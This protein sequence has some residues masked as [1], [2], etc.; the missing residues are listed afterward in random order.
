MPPMPRE[1]SG[2]RVLVLW[3]QPEQN[4]GVRPATVGSWATAA[5]WASSSAKCCSIRVRTSAG[6]SSLNKR[7]AS[8]RAIKVG[9]KSAVARSRVLALGLGIDHSPPLISPS[10]SL[11][12]PNTLGRTSLRQLYSCSLIWYSIIWRFSSTTRISC[13]PV[14]NSRVPWASNGHTTPTLCTRKPMRW[15]VAGSRPKSYSAWL[16]SLK[17]LPL[18]MTPRRSL[19]LS[20]TL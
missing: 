3:G 6:K 7:L 19:A 10:V 17:A 13:K 11:N 9:F 14:A 2:K 16:R 12:C 20:T 8:A 18:A 15:H 4:Q 1:P 5:S